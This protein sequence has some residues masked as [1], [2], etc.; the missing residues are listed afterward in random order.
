MPLKRRALPAVTKRRVLQPYRKRGT[1]TIRKIDKAI[2]A[3]RQR[4][5]RELQK[6]T[7]RADG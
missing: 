7:Q 1:L 3:I 6:S 5:L 2:E 4:R